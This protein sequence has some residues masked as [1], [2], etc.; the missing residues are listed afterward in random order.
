LISILL[1]ALSSAREQ[2]NQVKCASNLRQL[3]TALVAYSVEYK[4]KF[5]PTLTGP[6]ATTA[7]V[8]FKDPNVTVNHENT[9]YQA[10]RIGRNLGK[11]QTLANTASAQNP[12][13]ATVVGDLMVCPSMQASNVKRTYA[14]NI[15]ASSLINSSSPP[16]NGLNPGTGE[17][18]FGKLFNTST[19]NSTELML[20]T[21]AVPVNAAG[22][23]LFANPTVGSTYIAGVSSADFV[24]QQWGAGPAVWAK[25]SSTLAA[26]DS[27]T[28]IAWS[29]HRK[30]GQPKAGAQG[31]N[32]ANTP[33]GRVNIAFADGHVEMVSH[34]DVADFN[35]NKSTFRAL[36]STK[37]RVL[38][39]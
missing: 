23:D 34:T 24:A 17:H 37:D 26:A 6:T 14:M 30:R 39:K 36:W 18:P 35:N 16:P 11:P 7:A 13:M 33:Y 9:W 25:S 28:N 3:A 8:Q 5:P 27:R 1:P 20:L 21:E 38:Q 22:S 32:E 31:T 2:A 29:A 19:K 10:G 4:G 12:D 15:W